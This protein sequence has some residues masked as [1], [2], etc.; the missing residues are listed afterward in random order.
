VK[1]RCAFDITVALGLGS[2]P[3]ISLKEARQRRDEARRLLAQG[4]DPAK[5]L[6]EQQAQTRERLVA[7]ALSTSALACFID[8]LAFSIAIRNGDAYQKN[9][10]VLYT[11]PI[12]D[13]VMP[14]PVYDTGWNA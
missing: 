5:A 4:I 3:S 13:A 1:S 10:G 9:F 7:P 14:G 6:G 2:Y 12:H 8:S 11:R